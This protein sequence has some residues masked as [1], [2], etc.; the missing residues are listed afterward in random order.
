MK[1]VEIKCQSDDVIWKQIKWNV[2]NPASEKS[3]F[4]RRASKI[5]KKNSLEDLF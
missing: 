4:G 5:G 3:K 1:L 2:V